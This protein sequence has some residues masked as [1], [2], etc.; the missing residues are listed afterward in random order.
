MSRKILLAIII[1]ALVIAAG[2][3]SLYHW[4]S[5]RS[6]ENETTT[7]N[8][9]FK[10][11]TNEEYGFSFE[12]RAKYSSKSVID[13]D[14]YFSFDQN[15]S[16]EGGN[17]QEGVE[18]RVYKTNQDVADLVRQFEQDI[19]EGIFNYKAQLVSDNIYEI[20]NVSDALG[21]FRHHDLL[22]IDQ[23][24]RKA[25]RIDTFSGDGQYSQKIGQEILQTF[26]F[27]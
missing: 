2:A 19:N 4:Q 1:V 11:Y 18:V 13:A 27:F 14:A 7:E 8:G 26:K 12:Y 22:I 25:V 6:V 24:Q 3:M 5:L 15:V 21:F 23:S 10:T 16:G 17:P 20:P 9:D